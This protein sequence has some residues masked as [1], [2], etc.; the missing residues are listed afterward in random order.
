M[1]WTV[2]EL[3]LICK[4][5]LEIHQIIRKIYYCLLFPNLVIFNLPN[6]NLKQN[7]YAPHSNNVEPI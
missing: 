5:Y 7:L 1:A 3:N 6:S 2:V 4:T